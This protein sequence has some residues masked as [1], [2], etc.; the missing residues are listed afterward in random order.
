MNAPLGVYALMDDEQL[1]AAIASLER[2][3]AN[4]QFARGP[5]APGIRAGYE[6]ALL[7]ARR[8][9]ERRAT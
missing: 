8:E 6:D 1:T 3:V 2:T 7:A 4:L 9:L 5:L